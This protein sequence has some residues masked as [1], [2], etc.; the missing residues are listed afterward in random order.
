MANADQVNTDGD[1]AG[2]A[3]DLCPTDANKTEA[4]TCGCGVAD[5]DSDSDGTLVC[6]DCDDNDPD[7]HPG[8]TE[9][10][11]NNI[12]DNCNGE[13]DEDCAPPSGP[14][15]T[16]DSADGGETWGAGTFQTITWS[17]VDVTG[18]VSIQLSRDGGASWQTIM[19]MGS[20]PNDGSQPW[21]VT[22]PATTQALIRISSISNSEVF[23]VSD[24]VFII[25]VPPCITVT[26]PDGGETWMAGTFKMITWERSG[27]FFDN[28]RIELS[29][30]GGNHW[31]TIVGFT[32]NDG[33]Q[34][35][36]VTGPA[37]TNAL[38]RV[39]RIFGPACS[40]ISD[41]VF[42]ITA[43]PPPPPPP[44][45]PGWWWNWWRR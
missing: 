5:T 37:T 13:T 10:C 8:A 40:D 38:V 11:G 41:A 28:V 29:R 45:R 17:S 33:S 12:D 43:P 25:T 18:N 6:N 26:S 44:H 9:A 2:D 14:E 20:T 31:Q 24:A 22:G 3:C 32:G 30:D 15:I 42:N 21:M 36:M 34:L 1:G 4:G 23:D 7:V 19:G 27:R 16:V 39:T 35:W